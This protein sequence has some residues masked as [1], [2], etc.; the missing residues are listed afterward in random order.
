MKSA[1]GEG[2]LGALRNSAAGAALKRVEPPAEA[3]RLDDRTQLLRSIQLGAVQLK[4]ATATAGINH[5]PL[6]KIEVK[7]TCK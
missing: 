2:L 4:S 3:A 5:K 7:V 1:L 6:Q